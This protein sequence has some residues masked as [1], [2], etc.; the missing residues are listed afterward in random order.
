MKKLSLLVFLLLF[1]S[2]L[3]AQQRP[4]LYSVSIP[5]SQ[6]QGIVIHFDAGWGS[7]S[8]GSPEASY[9]DRRIGAVWRMNSQWTLLSNVGFG[10][11]ARSENAFSGQAEVFYAVKNANSTGLS[12]NVGGGARW[13]DEDGAVA[14]LHAISGWRAKQWLLES[15]VILEKASSPDRDPVDL[16]VSV[17]W[18][19]RISPNVGLGVES[20]GQDLEGFWEKE[21]AEGG[22]RILTGPSVHLRFSDWEAG[23]AGGYVFRPTYN[24]RSSGADRAFGSD[25]IAVQFSLSRSF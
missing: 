12:L 5:E 19:Y 17:G 14:L 8:L 6:E 1:A 21:E 25:R 2:T 18:L 16:I 3:Y 7:D 4:F 9:I 11:N 23:I 22:A 10:E 24:I 20:V 13:E 15:S